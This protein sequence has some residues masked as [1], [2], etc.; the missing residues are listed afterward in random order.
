VEVVTDVDVL[1]EAAHPSRPDR[2][3]LV[4][5]HL[6][7]IK[8]EAYEAGLNDPGSSWMR[9]VEKWRGEGAEEVLE[10]LIE[11]WTTTPGVYTEHG[12]VLS[13]AWREAVRELEEL[14]TKVRREGS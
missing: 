9:D 1:I 11:K 10:V 3:L 4:A 14:A 2:L 6:E 13:L 5:Q 12:S 7:R 8:A